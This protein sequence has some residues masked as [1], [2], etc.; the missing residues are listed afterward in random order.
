LVLFFKKERLLTYLSFSGE[1]LLLDPEG[2]L[3][4]P[5]RRLLAVADLHL[6]KG[7]AGRL[8]PLDTGATLD[9]LARLLRR[10]R[11]A[12]LVALGDSFHD[13]GGAARLQPRDAERIAAIGRACQIVWVLGNH[14][15]APPAGL[16]GASVTELRLGRL[17]LR[18]I[19]T[20]ETAEISGHYHPK[21]SIPTGAAT[22][23]RPCFV[24]DARRLL[25]PALGAYAGGLDVRDPAIGRLF[26]HGGRVFLLGRARLF[27][28]ALPAARNA[29]QNPFLPHI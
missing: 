23:T 7:S 26:P 16:P 18:H 28:F 25:L 15:P 19:A 13:I 27:S 1:R 11:P 3:F 14:D 17:V 5:A 8:P 4:W 20:D 10:H 2:G 21:A 9:R 6:E 12:T 24:A 22:V 29:A